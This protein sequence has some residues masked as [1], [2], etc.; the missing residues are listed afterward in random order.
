MCSCGVVWY[1]YSVYLRKRKRNSFLLH[2]PSFSFDDADDDDQA[3]ISMVGVFSGT[4]RI[5]TVYGVVFEN[6]IYINVHTSTKGVLF[7]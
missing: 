4:F 5:G 7:L 1:L 6:I 2:Q 3:C